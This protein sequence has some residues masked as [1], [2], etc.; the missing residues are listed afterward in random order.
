MRYQMPA[1]R[2]LG[3]GGEG[4][5][6]LDG[7]DLDR[8][9]HGQARPHPLGQGV[10]EHEGEL[11]LGA[12]RLGRRNVGHLVLVLE[13]GLVD[14]E[15]RGQAE[16]GLALLDGDDAP[17]GEALAVAKPVDLVDDRRGQVP[18][19]D[20]VPVRGVDAAVRR[21]RLRRGREGLPEHLSAEDG[22]PPEVLAFA[23]KQVAIDALE[24]EQVDQVLQGS[25]S[26]RAGS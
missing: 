3:D 12:E 4:V 8:A 7:A 11:R 18:G 5:S 23:A 22:P 13:A 2:G 14:V 20:E 26:I 19:A 10:G 9:R 15:G 25:S 24:R 21:D 1:H 17:G 16:D 6:E